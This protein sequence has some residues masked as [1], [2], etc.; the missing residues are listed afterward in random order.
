MVFADSLRRFRKAYGLTQKDVSDAIGIQPSAYQAYERGKVKP[1]IEV[2]IKIAEAFNVSADYLLGLDETRGV[3]E[4]YLLNDFREL[5]SSG[6]RSLIDY[7][8]F[9]RLKYRASAHFS[10][11]ITIG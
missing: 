10:T 4:T 2:L 6:Q 9:L 5:D 11:N 1:S 8:E 7:A 3:K